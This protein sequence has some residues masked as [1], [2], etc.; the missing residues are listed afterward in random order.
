MSDKLLDT[1]RLTAEQAAKIF[2][3]VFN[4]KFSAKQISD[5]ANK[6]GLMSTDGT[7]SLIEYTAYISK[8]IS[9]GSN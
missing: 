6:G 3:A 4:R 2:S 5:L 8:E 7:F 9:N 1:N